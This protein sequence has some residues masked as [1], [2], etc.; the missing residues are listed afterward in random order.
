MEQ[1]HFAVLAIGPDQNGIVAA[2][3]GALRARQL[4]IE[5]SQMATLGDHFSM[6]LVVRGTDID[7]G[8]LKRE[9]S[10]VDSV[11]STGER[12]GHGCEILVKGLERYNT[13]KPHEP[14]HL[15]TLLCPDR[16]GVISAISAKLSELG[17]NITHL[18]SEVHHLQEESM[19]C[20]TK[21]FVA[22]PRGLAYDDLEAR[23]TEWWDHDDNG[24]RERTHLKVECL[25]GDSPN[26]LGW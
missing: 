11:S 24:N 5:T 14:T 4:S 10:G 1:E 2:I 6:V 16:Q 21:V 26:S 25:D 13:L 22:L 20:T 12:Q 9:L 8:E 18:H 7:S 15:I 19:F 3:T 17:V 23:L